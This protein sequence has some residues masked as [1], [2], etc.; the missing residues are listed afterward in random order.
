MEDKAMP[1]KRKWKPNLF[2]IVFIVIVLAA[3]WFII[4]IFRPSGSSEASSSTTQ[5]VTYTVE[6][7]DMYYEGAYRIAPGD[8][9]IDNVENRLL[10]TVV[11]VE[12]VP[13]TKLERNAMTGERIITE[14][15]GRLTAITTIAAEA[16]VTEDQITLTS[17]FIIRVGTRVSANGPLY[18]AV[19]F[20]VNMERVDAA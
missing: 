19:G 12:L 13:S 16:T 3:A 15:P 4:G 20:I 11:S 10:G 17:G 9:L 14:Y 18:Y 5:T 6:F 1:D 2:D 7:S 8:V